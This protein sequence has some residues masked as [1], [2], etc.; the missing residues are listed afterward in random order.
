MQHKRPKNA[1][2]RKRETLGHSLKK[3]SLASLKS[4]SGF[5]L[6]ELLVVVAI[7][8]ILASV[9]LASLNSA[10]SKGN[11][12]A[13]KANLFNMISQAELSYDTPG[14]YS[15]AC[16]AVAGMLTAINNAG[17]TS[18]CYSYSNATYNDVN[19]R[20]GAT[21]KMNQTAFQAYSVDSNGVVTWDS[22][23]QTPGTA[24]TWAAAVTACQN[25]GAHLPTPE[26]LQALWVASGSVNPAPGFAAY[27]YWS[28]VTVPS[29][30]NAAYSVGMNTNANIYIS[31]KVGSNLYV[32]CVK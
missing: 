19:T 26:Q 17:A 9:V 7:I 16:T 5:T 2:F 20:W 8:G 27:L 22:V 18:S 24:M 14:N 31:N 29:N 25:E 32:R 3:P 4:S 12:A 1:G 28:S 6:I 21:A 30:I 13:V 15:A 11:V 23:D 10:R